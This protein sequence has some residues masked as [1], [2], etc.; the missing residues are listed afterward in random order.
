M[1]QLCGEAPA[2][3]TSVRKGLFMSIGITV[4]AALGIGGAL[5][6]VGGHSHP[7]VQIG[8]AQVRPVVLEAASMGQSELVTTAFNYIK[9]ELNMRETEKLTIGP[10]GLCDRATMHNFESMHDAWAVHV[11]NDVATLRPYL[12]PDRCLQTDGKTI[13]WT[14][15]QSQSLNP[16]VFDGQFLYPKG[17]SDVVACCR[18]EGEPITFED[19]TQSKESPP[20]QCQWGVRRVVGPWDL[21]GR[22]TKKHH[23]HPDDEGDG[24]YDYH[25]DPTSPK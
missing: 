18:Q 10:H 1:E 23:P 13:D 22:W 11:E 2:R 12:H 7:P 9:L 17:K 25:Y 5:A 16:L 14:C 21:S 4:G 15:E 3:N 6:S 24:D 19:F 8:G 20:W